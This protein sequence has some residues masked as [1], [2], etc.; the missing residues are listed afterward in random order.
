MVILDAPYASEM[1]LDWLEESQHPVLANDFT[2]GLE[3]R[4]LHLVDDAEAAALVN[5]GQRVYTNS[6]NALAWL[7]ENT[8][9]EAL[10]RG[11]ELF[12][13]KLEMRRALASL[14][15]DVFFRE[16]SA[17]ELAAVDFDELPDRVVLKPTVGFC[18]MGVYVITSRDEWDAALTDIQRDAERWQRMYP[19]SVV[20]A[21]RFIIESYIDGQEYAIDAFFDSEGRAQVLNV[22]K[23]DFASPEDTSDRL[24]TCG[25]AIYREM[26]PV[27]TEWL[28]KVNQVIDVRDLPVH[29]EVRVEDGHVSPIEFNPLRFA[30]LGGTDVSQHAFGFKTYQAYL[31]DALPDA[32]AYEGDG[33]DAVYTMS[34]LN[35][36]A[37][38]DGT[39][40]FDYD[41]FAARFSDV[42]GFH[43]FDVSKVG[44]YGFLFVRADSLESPELDFLLHDD[45][46]EFITSAS[47]VAAADTAKDAPEAVDV[48]VED[49]V[50]TEDAG[51]D[52]LSG[53]ASVPEEQRD[54]A[55][56]AEEMR[57]GMAHDDSVHDDSVAIS[58]LFAA[59]KRDPGVLSLP[60]D[61]TE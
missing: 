55:S 60:F 26:A 16:V 11:I 31:E 24:Y 33:T 14:D 50:S 4:A 35:P 28:D 32:S 49:A 19:E 57:A 20:D 58:E 29:V 34:L 3:G 44:S 43:R 54:G 21:Q 53:D 22:L 40:T 18:S 23:H 15:E 27:F 39:E 17:D 12:K 45:L 25:P 8:Q 30:G 38:T 56:A 47:D 9:V 61:L 10:A 5:A 13:D 7:A 41:A 51:T 59:V 1:L 46:R 37:D 36:P 52:A 48:P 2:R 42:R 6:E